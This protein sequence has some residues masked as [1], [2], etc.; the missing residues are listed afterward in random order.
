LTEVNL[1]SVN[2]TFHPT[3]IWDFSLASHPE[4]GLKNTFYSRDYTYIDLHSIMVDLMICK[5]KLRKC[6][7]PQNYIVSKMGNA[8]HYRLPILVVH[9]KQVESEIT[10][11]KHSEFQLSSLNELQ[12]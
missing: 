2:K 4:K 8:F 12:E 11:A 3:I 6:K 10:E 5:I 1:K 7:F 9:L